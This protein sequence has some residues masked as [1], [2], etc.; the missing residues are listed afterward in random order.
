MEVISVNLF[1]K[2]WKVQFPYFG[3]YNLSEQRSLY[4]CKMIVEQ[5]ITEVA[6]EILQT[7]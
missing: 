1:S 3:I 2:V 7:K 5:A 6:P 4:H